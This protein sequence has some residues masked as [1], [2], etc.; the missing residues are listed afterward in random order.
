MWEETYPTYGPGRHACVSVSCLEKDRMWLGWRQSPPSVGDRLPRLHA[1]FRLGDLRLGH[2]RAQN[3]IGFMYGFGEGVPPRDDVE[4]YKW[5]T[6]AIARY[7]AR[8]R[9]TP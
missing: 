1:L 5:L 7:T 3:D 4:A 6:L 9:M 8:H 2:A